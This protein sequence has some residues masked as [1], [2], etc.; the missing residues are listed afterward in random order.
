MAGVD[1]TIRG[2]EV[3]ALLGENGAG[4]TTLMRILAGIVRPDDGMIEIAGESVTL[5]DRRDGTRHGIGMIQ[6]H[7]AL[8]DE[9]TAAENYLLGRPDAS[10]ITNMKEAYGELRDAADRLG[11]RVD[12]GA[13]V[14][15]LT[16]G[17]RQRLETAIAVS[18][19]ARVLIMDE[20]T[21]ALGI[22]DAGLVM[23]ISRRLADEGAGI[24][25]ITHKLKEVMEVSDRVSVLRRGKLVLTAE[26]AATSAKELTNAMVESVPKAR[27]ARHQAA[28]AEP[29]ARLRNISVEEAGRRVGLDDVSLEVNG[30]EILGVAG[31]VGNGQDA[32]ARVVTG[33]IQPSG[34]HLDLPSGVVAYVPEDRAR[35]GLASELSVR[36]NAIVHRHRDSALQRL[37]RL[38]PKPVEDFVER[39]LER[40]QVRVEHTGT[41]ASAL[42]GGN[43]QKLV[44][45]RELDRAS[46]VIVAHNPYRG[47]DIGATAE[48]R[49]RLLEARDAG[50]GILMISP[51]LDELFD[52]CARLVVLFEGR[53]VGELDARKA[54]VQEVGRLMAGG[55]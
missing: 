41:P 26:T 38:A 3:H 40:A 44:L 29:V 15:D 14:A 23:N 45:G 17:E 4:K 42:S 8:I 21:A 52:V 7:F 31:V 6:Q 50:A 30:G 9:L 28:K 39:L 19:G 46:G 20:P 32:L 33:L 16:M 13:L 25:F 55:T 49:E 27:S 53:I 10:A 34:G 5:H 1:I 48:I 36:D 35:E 11:L 22:E 12:P 2:G 37:G 54:K 18:T 24:V 43:Q 51:D 47:L